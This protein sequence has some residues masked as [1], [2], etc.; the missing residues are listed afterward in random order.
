VRETFSLGRVAGV[1]VG[2]HWS[3]LVIFAIIA[4]GLARG[5]LPDAYPD[6]PQ[7]QY[8]LVGLIAAVVFFAS[9]L[10]HEVAHSIVA[11]RNGIGV[12]SI[13]LWLLGGAARLKDEAASPGAELRIAGIG[14]LVSL[15][16]GAL[17]AGATAVFDASGAAGLATEAVAW[18]AAINILLAIFNSIPAA[19]L[20]GGRL[21]RA[22]VWWR[23][24]DRRRA[25]AVATAAGRALGWAL[26]ALGA[27]LFLRGAALSGIWF[28]VIGWFLIAVATAEGRQAQV[29]E[30]L[31]GVPVREAMTPDPVT[32]P[33]TTTV[34]ELV[35]GPLSRRRHA[36]LPVTADDAG[37]PVGLVTLDRVK[38]VPT[39]K[40]PSTTLADVMVPMSQVTTA[41]PADPLAQI[42][43][44]LD[45][46]PEHRVLVL[47]SDALVGI[48]SPS[49]VDRT[50]NWLSSM[51]RPP[52]S[53]R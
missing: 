24:G 12:D 21:L 35:E 39:E 9:L 42:A 53:R 47:E 34:Q 6:H 50:L 45:A 40:R 25:T 28:A 37:H 22:I 23:T 32:A 36:A 17:F 3:V 29:Q 44:R 31:G 38:Q 8:W 27:Y 46:A 43:S 41:D 20:D 2:V 30:T 33:V 18:L 10:A 16:L 7:W 13:T 5:H 48:V 4:L 19:P 51:R 26:L 52:G 11:H 49:D 14:P 1:R 15:A